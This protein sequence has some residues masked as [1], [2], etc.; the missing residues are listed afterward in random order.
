MARPDLFTRD[1]DVIGRLEFHLALEIEIG[2]PAGAQMGKQ[3]AGI[4][5]KRIA[6]DFHFG[7]RRRLRRA[8]R[9]TGPCRHISSHD[10]R[11]GFSSPAPNPYAGRCGDARSGRRRDSA[12]R[13]RRD[14]AS[15]PRPAREGGAKS[16]VSACR[17]ARSGCQNWAQQFPI[18]VSGADCT[19]SC[20]L[21]ALGGVASL[22]LRLV[23]CLLVFVRWRNRYNVRRIARVE[24]MAATSD[25]GT[26][27]GRSAGILRFA[28]VA[29]E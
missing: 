29:T 12:F 13:S 24:G 28:A 27:G 21:S 15:S 23:S 2:R 18:G 6:G 1:D 17:P 5:A 26:S 10:R 7:C 8:L 16:R 22:V 25:G 3:H 9:C 14:R 19:S 20:R 11:S 4:F